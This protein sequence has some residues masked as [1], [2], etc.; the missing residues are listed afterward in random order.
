MKRCVQAVFYFLTATEKYIIIII[1][2]IIIIIIIIIISVNKPS[3]KLHID[4]YNEIQSIV[5]P[6][7][8]KEK[9]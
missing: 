7:H 5:V 3:R 4:I 8:K 6:Y 9:P 2:I 1:V